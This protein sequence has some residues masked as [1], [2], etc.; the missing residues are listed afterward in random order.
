MSAARTRKRSPRAEGAAARPPG[1]GVIGLGFIGREHLR[2]FRAAHEAGQANVLVAVC[3]TDALR[4]SGKAAPALRAPPASAAPVSSEALFDVGRVR[5]TPHAEELLADPAVDLVVIATPT[6]THVELALAALAA[7]KH[8]LVEKPV[9]LRERDVARLAAAARAVR[10]APGG[11]VCLP[12]MCMRFWPGWEWLTVALAQRRFGNVRSAVFRR[13]SARPAWSAFYADIGRSGGV[14]FDLHVHDAD[15]VQALF[16]RPRAVTTSGSSDHV[17]TLYHHES[18]RAGQGGSVPRDSLATQAHIVA[19]AGWDHAP[20]F[21]FR[22]L[23]TVVCDEATLD[24][25]SRREAPLQVVR[26]GRVEDISLPEGNGYDGQARHLLK[27]VA[28]ARAG[29]AVQPAVSIDDAVAV[30]QLLAAESESLASGRTVE[31]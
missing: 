18:S 5:S 9:A 20:G 14:L 24:F 11:P 13:L 23:Y 31:L 8:V 7:G 16:G 27:V 22:M 15:F 25:D 19:E 29:R 26:D 30:T 1:V 28:A 12:A 17:T 6:D 10:S 3:D 2:A 4:L 21:E